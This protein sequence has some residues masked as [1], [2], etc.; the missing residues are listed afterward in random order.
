M[1][2]GLKQ[3]SGNNKIQLNVYKEIVNL[4]NPMLNLIKPHEIKKKLDEYV[5]GNEDVKRTLSTTLYNHYKKISYKGDIELDKS[6]M[7]L[8]GPT[9][10]G[11]TY[12]IKTIAKILNVPY[13]IADCTTLTESGYVGSDVET[14]LDGLLE[15]AEGKHELAEMGIV[16]MDE[17][18]K[19]S[20]KSENRSI[21]RDVSGEGVQQALLKMLEG[22][23][24][25]IQPGRKRHH[26]DAPYINFNTKNVLFIGMGA[27]D[28]I[29]QSIKK[30]LNYNRIGYT[31]NIEEKINESDENHILKHVTTEDLRKFGLIPELIG[32]M[33]IITTTEQLSE[34]AL[35]NII[36]KPKN[37]ILKQ[38]EELFLMDG[39]TLSFT[40]DALIAVA[41]EAIK[42]KTGARSLRTIL[43]KILQGYMYEIPK[44]KVKKLKITKEIVNS[45][46]N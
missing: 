37:A 34:E 2:L 42:L 46:L 33:P 19:I 32:R 11:K 4:N 8:L 15:N 45:K 21:T 22:S 27:F 17:I 38:Y 6:N 31:S 9:G 13:Y 30:R 5:I 1:L 24:I 14:V 35:V 10:S 44:T 23:I 3:M 16:I 41:K 20:R 28:G 18:D 43:E 25:R 29:E 12:L 39:C 36:T 26:P 40:D 7:I